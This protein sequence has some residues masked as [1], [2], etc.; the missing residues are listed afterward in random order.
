MLSICARPGETTIS[1]IGREL[2]VTRQAASKIVAR[3][4]PRGYLDAAPSDTDA[5]EKILT[6][7][8]RAAELMAARRRA[9]ETI[10]T[11]LRDEIGDQGVDELITYLEVLGGDVPAPW[12]PR[13]VESRA[14]RAL[15][16]L[17]DD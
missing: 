13:S 2:G 15:R 10:E 16:L 7:T 6:V 9:A 4:R 14:V 3:F 17:D 1:D 8:P 5:R 12:D 11:W